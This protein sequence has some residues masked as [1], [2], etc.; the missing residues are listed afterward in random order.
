MA[1]DNVAITDLKVNAVTTTPAGTA[2]NPANGATIAAPGPMRKVSVRVTNTA[3][4]PYAVT[5]RAG[6]YPTSMNAS[7]G[8]LAVTVPATTGDVVLQLDGSRFQ[9]DDGSVSVD[10]A[11]GMTGFISVLR[12]SKYA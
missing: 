7:L 4:S 10:F 11:T 2:I 3:A 12:R 5:F 8:D 1:R 9:Q 6:T